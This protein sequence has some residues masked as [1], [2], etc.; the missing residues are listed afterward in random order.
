MKCQKISPEKIWNIPGNKFCLK[1]SSIL[2]KCQKIPQ[3]EWKI[4]T[5]IEKYSVKTG[6][7]FLLKC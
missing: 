3:K 6:C 5:E 2:I 4:S 1:R 7:H